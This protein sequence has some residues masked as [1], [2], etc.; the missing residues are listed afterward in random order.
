MLHGRVGI[1]ASV[2]NISSTVRHLAMAK[3]RLE[4]KTIVSQVSTALSELMVFA[5]SVLHFP[6]GLVCQ[7]TLATSS[8]TSSGSVFVLLC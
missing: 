7:D 8:T 2:S 5:L 1:P 3:L 6:L 4:G